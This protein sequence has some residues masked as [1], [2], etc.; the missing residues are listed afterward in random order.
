MNKFKIKL[1]L[2]IKFKNLINLRQNRDLIPLN[3][4]KLL[5]VTTEKK[6]DKRY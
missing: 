2:K 3:K 6:V 4:K 1:N 5:S